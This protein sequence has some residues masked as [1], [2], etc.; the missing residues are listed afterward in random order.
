VQVQGMANQRHDYVQWSLE[1]LGGLGAGSERRG[2]TG[3]PGRH[4]ASHAFASRSEQFKLDK[5]YLRSSA[6]LT[7]SQVKAYLSQKLVLALS[8]DAVG[9]GS[10]SSST[11]STSS[12]GAS[13]GQVGLDTAMTTQDATESG[14]V[15]AAAAAAAAAAV[16]TSR[17]IKVF[18]RKYPSNAV[19]YLLSEQITFF[20]SNLTHPCLINFFR[21]LSCQTM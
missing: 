2:G 16:R 14:K 15:I 18:T 7:V 4:S 5:P 9:A 20:M 1:P 12:V 11:S 3:G 17:S 13:G 19:S 10:T 6:T 8:S 21:L